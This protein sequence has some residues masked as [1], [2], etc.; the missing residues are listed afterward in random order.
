MERD[1]PA[2][3]ARQGRRFRE[4]RQAGRRQGP[5]AH[6][7]RRHQLGPAP[8]A[9]ERQRLQVQGRR[10]GQALQPAGRRPTGASGT[11]PTT[12]PSRPRRTRSARRSSTRSSRAC[13][14]AATSSR[15]TSSTK[16][17]S[18]RTSRAG[19]RRPGRR[20]RPRRSSGSTT[21][22]RSTAA[23]RRRRPPITYPGTARIIKAV[24]KK[25]TKAKFWY[26][27][28]GGLAKFGGSFPC[29]K[30]R[31]ANRTSF[32]FDMIKTYDKDV[33]RLYSYNWFGADCVSFDA[34]LV[35]DDGTLRPAYSHVQEQA[36]E[37]RQVAGCSPGARVGSGAR[38]RVAEWHR[39][40]VLKTAVRKS[41]RVRIPPRASS[42][43]PHDTRAV[44][45]LRCSELRN[46]DSRCR[47]AR[48]QRR[49]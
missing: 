16:P 34:G 45:P 15:S 26:T 17:A 40:A 9:A 44:Q 42:R 35:E 37:R 28:T 20:A 43:C 47:V 19:S 33:E 25:N 10:A 21:T 39:R 14:R 41:V 29:N 13:A 6:L 31:Q 22:R 5:D 30:S 23:S 27:E 36:E 11:R 38:A 8:R 18:R 12:S 3:G 7:D 48:W 24:R 4:R 1:R 32:M 46:F 2:R 49:G